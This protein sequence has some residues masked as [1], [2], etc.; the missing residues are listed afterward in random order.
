[1]TDDLVKRL[2][3]TF[4]SVDPF[5][6]MIFQEAAS[7]IEQLEAALRDVYEVYAG[8]EGIPQPMTAAEGYLLHLVKE[9]ANTARAALGEKKND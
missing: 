6:A 4:F 1:M 7:R 3:D 2:R 9:M 5:D 8:S